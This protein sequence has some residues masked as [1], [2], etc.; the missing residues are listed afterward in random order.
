[1]LGGGRRR[2]LVSGR[3]TV[4]RLGFGLGNRTSYWSRAL[5]RRRFSDVAGDDG[6]FASR[7][8]VMG[9]VAA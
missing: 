4:G 6:V 9:D 1:M 8:M 2:L 7:P 3:R 5:G